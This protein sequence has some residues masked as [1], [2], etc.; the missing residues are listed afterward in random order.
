MKARPRCFRWLFWKGAPWE[1]MCYRRAIG[2]RQKY[3]TSILLR[4]VVSISKL[5]LCESGTVISLLVRAYDVLGGQL[6]IDN[7]PLQDYNIQVKS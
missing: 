6:F 3:R 4:I 1:N 5:C 2:Q 7:I